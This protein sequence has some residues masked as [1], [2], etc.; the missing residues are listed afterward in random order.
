MLNSILELSSWF[1]LGCGSLLILIGGIGIMRMPDVFCRM[2]A[3]SI[4]DT[5][6]AMLVI[7]GLALQNGWDLNLVKLLLIIVFLL[8]TTPVSTHALAKA[9]RHSQA[10][11]N[12]ND[13]P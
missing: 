10:T 2:H 6:G 9:A 3:S 7:S 8:L 4:T 1:L 11:G 5:M 12:N 13:Q